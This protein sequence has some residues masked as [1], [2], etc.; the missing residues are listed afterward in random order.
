MKLIFSYTY[1]NGVDYWNH[2]TPFYYES[3]E[4]AII[5]FEALVKKAMKDKADFEFAGEDLSPWDFYEE[6]ELYL[7]E[8]QTVAEWFM[9]ADGEGDKEKDNIVQE[10]DELFGPREV[11]TIELPQEFKDKLT[12]IL[13]G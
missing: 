3:A 5:D 8:I 12:K 13:I 11:T 7:P 9:G 10:L 4:K 6:G 1:S 2:V